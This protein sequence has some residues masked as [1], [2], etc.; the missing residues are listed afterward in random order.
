MRNLITLIVSL[1]LVISCGIAKPEVPIETI[2]NYKDSTV[3]TMV[4][5]VVYIPKERIVDV[6][7]E[8]DTL[9][10]ETNMAKARAYV[11]TA[12]H[13]LR[14][15]IENKKDIQ[16]KFIYKDRIEYKDSIITK[17]VPVDIVHEKTITKHPFYESLLWLLS[18]V[19]L[20]Y[21][22]LKIYMKRYVK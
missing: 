6:V 2:Y 7:A 4:D 9:T 21:V 20:F 19:F 18:I 17:E 13:L 14:G 22:G 8:Y 16:Y 12:L 15:S 10:L 3:V 5:S 11:D 1:L